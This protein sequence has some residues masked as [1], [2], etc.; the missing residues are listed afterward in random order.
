MG[1]VRVSELLGQIS[2]GRLRTYQMF[3]RI[4]TRLRLNK[5]N[6]ENLKKIAPKVWARILEGDEV[7]ALELAQ[8][9][10]VSHLEMIIEILNFLGVPHQEGFF[11]KDAEIAA[12]LTDG[13]QQR[14]LDNFRAKHPETLLLFYVNHLAREVSSES[15]VFVPAGA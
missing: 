8:S 5:L 13:W 7:L 10:L 11:E 1:Q 15:Q 6:Q 9:I 2:I 12:H 14:V 4:K 3:D